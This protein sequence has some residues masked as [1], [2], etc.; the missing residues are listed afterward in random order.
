MISLVFLILGLFFIFLEF[1]IPGGIMTILGSIMLALSVVAFANLTDSPMETLLFLGSIAFLLFLL[2]RFTLARIPKAKPGYSI[3][4]H[5]DQEGY[6]A[7]SYDSQA[8]G[9]T[10]T[11]LTDL[12][13]GG[14]ILIDDKK[15]AAISIEGYL[16]QGTQVVVIRGEEDQLIVRKKTQTQTKKE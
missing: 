7:S 5:T 6:Q 14:F 4:L 1:Y 3:Y 2:I 16:V 8:I 15:Y 12:K 13:P 10:G 11:V 9:K